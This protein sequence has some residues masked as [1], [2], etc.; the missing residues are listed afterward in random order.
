MNQAS[1]IP[2]WSDHGF[3][4][5]LLWFSEMSARGLLFHPDD[6]PADIIHVTSGERL[7]SDNEAHELRDTLS[8]MFK[9]EGDMVYEAGLPIFRAALGQFDA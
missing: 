8:V 5:M 1:R 9:Q 2:Q 7:F 6:D 4:G 3:D